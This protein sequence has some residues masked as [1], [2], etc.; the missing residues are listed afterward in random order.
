[1]FTSS[2]C[3]LSMLSLWSPIFWPLHRVEPGESGTVQSDDPP[4]SG[5]KTWPPAGPEGGPPSSGQSNTR[6]QT[7][8]RYC[9]QSNTQVIG[10]PSRQKDAIAGHMLRVFL[11]FAQSQDC[12]SAFSGPWDHMEVSWSCDH[13][14]TFSRPLAVHS[15]TQLS[16]DCADLVVQSWVEPEAI[17]GKFNHIWIRHC[18]N[19]DE[20][21]V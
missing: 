17:A 15:F 16:R 14:S 5:P 13:A 9:W 1:M 8:R 19:F 2:C 21:K 3:S 6:D 7:H 12:T 10:T 11:R 20:L 18:V 4:E